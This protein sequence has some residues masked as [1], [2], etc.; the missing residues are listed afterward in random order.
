LT[1]KAESFEIHPMRGH[2][3][4]EWYGTLDNVVESESDAEYWAVS[5][6]MHRGNRHCL[7]EFSTKDAALAAIR[8]KAKVARKNRGNQGSRT[9]V[10]IEVEPAHRGDAKLRAFALFSDGTVWRRKRRTSSG[11]GELADRWEAI[12]FDDL[13]SGRLRDAFVQAMLTKV[14]NS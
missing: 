10:H 14:D 9:I 8:G 2:S 6:V 11:S 5:G 1:E 12:D 7:G 3:R 13:P 4:G